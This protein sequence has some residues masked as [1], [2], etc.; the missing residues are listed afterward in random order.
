[1][2]MTHLNR[3]FSVKWEFIHN[4]MQIF[5]ILDIDNILGIMF[6]I[7]MANYPTLVNRTV[8]LTYHG[9]LSRIN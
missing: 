4:C 9:I 8:H 7:I 5:A 6:T 3:S 1:M 2:Q